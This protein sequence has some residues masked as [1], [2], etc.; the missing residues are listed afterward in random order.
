MSS[1]DGEGMSEKYALLKSQY[2]A[3][4]SKEA[5]LIQSFHV[6]AAIRICA[7]TEQCKKR[8]ELDLNQGTFD[9]PAFRCLLRPGDLGKKIL[10]MSG[11][12]VPFNEQYRAYEK[13]RDILP[14]N[15]KKK[16]SAYDLGWYDN[17]WGFLMMNCVNGGG[18]EMT[19]EVTSVCLMRAG[20]FINHSTEN[21][22][23]VLLPQ[24][25]Y[26]R[27]LGFVAVRD[28]KEGEEITIT[29][30]DP[31]LSK[32]EKIRL[33]ATQYFIHEVTSHEDTSPES[34]TTDKDVPLEIS[35]DP[36]APTTTPETEIKIPDIV[37]IE[38]S[39][40]SVIDADYALEA[41]LRTEQLR[42]QQE[43]NELG[44]E[45]HK[46]RKEMGMDVHFHHQKE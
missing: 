24:R 39:A 1:N 43:M 17:I 14:S 4:G 19:G 32:D 46:L 16:V 6:L 25:D 26:N 13:V 10:D 11:F 30:V 28:M 31:S 18:V 21:H 15:L 36:P 8:G 41:E 42:L 40:E 23:C 2:A 22:N 12:R 45:N 5:P 38:A 37:E 34:V 20:S 35:T 27:N 29:Y 7:I 44:I 33:L 9:M 3:A